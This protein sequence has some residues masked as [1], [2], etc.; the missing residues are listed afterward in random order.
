MGRNPCRQCGKLFSDEADSC[1]HCGAP[2]PT[3]ESEITFRVLT[4]F[5]CLLVLSALASV[6]V[7]A[8]YITH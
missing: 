3:P 2:R 8:Y 6:A 5:G 7:A 1:P 4:A